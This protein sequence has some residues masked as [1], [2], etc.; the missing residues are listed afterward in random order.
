MIRNKFIQF[1]FSGAFA[2]INYVDILGKSVLREKEKGVL[3]HKAGHF[4]F[5]CF[6]FC[7]I[8]K[9]SLDHC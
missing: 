4:Q 8:S 1:S 5:I 2:N 9:E 6:A 3:F 7:I